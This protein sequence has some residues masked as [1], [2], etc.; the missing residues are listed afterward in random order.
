[1]LHLFANNVHCRRLFFGCHIGSYAAALERY[2]ANPIIA[3]RIVLLT[4]SESDEYHEPSPLRTSFATMSLPQIFQLGSSI[5]G[6]SG[7]A[8]DSENS[9]RSGDFIPKSIVVDEYEKVEKWRETA[10]KVAAAVQSEASPRRRLQV[11]R[12][13]VLLNIN[14]E[15][16]DQPLKNEKKRARQ[17]VEAQ[18]KEKKYCTYFHLLDSCKSGEICEYRHGPRLNT[19]EQIVLE[20]N[21]RKVPCYTGSRCLDPTCPFGHVCQMDEPCYYGD[22]CKLAM[23]HQVDRTAVRIW[24]RPNSKHFYC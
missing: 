9:M 18:M 7:Y 21:V 14:D 22:Q 12:K 8:A 4:I 11:S 19:D 3:P 1:M 13:P 20:N 5:S 6:S 10:D 2:A 15:R 23:F 17:N 24:H 16:V